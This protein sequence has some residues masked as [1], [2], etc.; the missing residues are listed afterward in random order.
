MFLVTSGL[1]ALAINWR[2]I[3]SALKSLYSFKGGHDE[4]P[5]MSKKAMIVFT[6]IGLAL[7]VVCL[8]VQFKLTITIIVAMIVFGGLILNMIATRAQ[9]Q[10]MINPARVMGILLMGVN[11]ALGAS[12]VNQ[13]LTGAGFVA[14]SGAQGGNLT[15]DMAYGHWYRI[16]ASWQFW[17]QAATIIACSLVAALVFYFL[18]MNFTLDLDGSGELPAP[19]AVIWANIA[20]LFDP[21]IEVVLPPFAI[22]SML[23]AGTVGVVWTFLENRPRIRRFLP[24][25]IGFG[26]ALILPLVYDFGFFFGAVMMFY[27]LKRFLKFSDITLTTMAI[28]CIVA[29]GV[30]GLLQAILKAVGVIGG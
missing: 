19:I 18:R 3:R 17:T 20:L 24:C 13:S 12:S 23:I 7:T 1:T 16:K 22:E 4:N 26:L 30:G 11:A 14:G 6:L 5:I 27:V 28:A 10:T 8:Y 25:S 21:N 29:E 2:M 9:A 15:A